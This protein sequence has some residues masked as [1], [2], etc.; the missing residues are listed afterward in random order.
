MDFSRALALKSYF[1]AG[2]TL[3][4]HDQTGRPVEHLTVPIFEDDRKQIGKILTATLASPP[5]SRRSQAPL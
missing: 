2:P 1:Y 4:F 3:D 5:S